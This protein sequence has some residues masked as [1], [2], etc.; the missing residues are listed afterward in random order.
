VADGRVLFPGGACLGPEAV[1]SR[2]SLLSALAVLPVVAGCH[3]ACWSLGP[4]AGMPRGRAGRVPS[5]KLDPAAGASP[6][7]LV[8][9]AGLALVNG[10]VVFAGCLCGGNDSPLWWRECGEAVNWLRLR[11][12]GFSAA[13]ALGRS[14]LRSLVR[15]WAA[16]LPAAMRLGMGGGLGCCAHRGN[17][18]VPGWGAVGALFLPWGVECLRQERCT[19]W[20]SSTDAE[21]NGDGLGPA[22]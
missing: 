16:R 21:D 13:Q 8:L 4:E 9:H 12:W 19:G 10:D 14:L 22:L 20:P 2:R 7:D 11:A 1:W 15:W 3:V 18:V 5:R 6:S 17:V